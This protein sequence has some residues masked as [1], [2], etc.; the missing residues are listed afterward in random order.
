MHLGFRLNVIVI[1]L[2]VK[3]TPK[4]R[5]DPREDQS[6]AAVERQLKLELARCIF[7]LTSLQIRV[8]KP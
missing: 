7:V 8:V 1:V 3:K 2:F 6:L 5:R 4:P